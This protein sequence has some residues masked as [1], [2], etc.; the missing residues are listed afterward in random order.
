LNRVQTFIGESNKPQVAPK[1]A[2]EYGKYTDS[3]ALQAKPGGSDNQLPSLGTV[4]ISRTPGPVYGAREG[5]MAPPD[6]REGASASAGLPQSATA[7]S[8]GYPSARP[9]SRPTAPPKPKSLRV[10]GQDSSRPSTSQDRSP[11]VQATPTS[12]GG[13]DWEANFSRRFP[14]LSGLEMET[15]IEAPKY[16][17]LRTREV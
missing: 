16:P 6:R 7:N 13:E 17:K 14:S 2:S 3:S 10:G 11:S 12:P 15:E 8:A 4:P 1:T 5:T 9:A